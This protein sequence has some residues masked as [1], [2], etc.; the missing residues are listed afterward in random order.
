MNPD[1]FI[2]NN[3]G[4]ETKLPYITIEARPGNLS[5]GGIESHKHIKN[6]MLAIKISRKGAR[7]R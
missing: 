5:P 3:I 1:K 6:T 2:G 7:S 4:L